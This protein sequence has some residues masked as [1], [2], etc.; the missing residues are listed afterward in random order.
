MSYVQMTLKSDIQINQ[1]LA[2]AQWKGLVVIFL[3]VVCEML[4]VLFFILPSTRS[5]VA[6]TFCLG[7][8]TLNSVKYNE[9][10]WKYTDLCNKQRS[11]Y[12]CWPVHSVA[13][14][15]KRCTS[16]C[17]AHMNF[18]IESVCL[19]AENVWSERKLLTL[20]IIWQHYVSQLAVQ[21]T[22]D[23][24]FMICQWWA[25]VISFISC[26]LQLVSRVLYHGAVYGRATCISEWHLCKIWTC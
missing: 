20:Y 23:N 3:R 14:H 9:V 26:L 25:A 21:F 4:F 19:L 17:K 6:W 24:L 18:S 12:F 13:L 8:F 1:Y 15:S 5:W 11:C 7:V 2:S 10:V 16:N 22:H